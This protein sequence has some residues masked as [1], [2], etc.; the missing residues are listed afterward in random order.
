MVAAGAV[1]TRDVPDYGLVTG[2]PARLKG[3]VCPCGKNLLK[4]SEDELEVLARCTACGCEISIQR[5][6][7]EQS[8]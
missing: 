3:F 5:S 8:G 4:A 7:W 6:V 2:M 1:V